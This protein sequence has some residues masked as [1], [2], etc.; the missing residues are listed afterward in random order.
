MSEEK[1]KTVTMS[2]SDLQALLARL[3]KL[4]QKDEKSESEKNKA[5]HEKYLAWVREENRRLEE[6]V[7][8]TAHYDGDK[9]KGYAQI[10]VNGAKATVLRGSSVM[11]KRKHKLVYDQAYEQ[12]V[13]ANEY[14]RS[15]AEKS[16]IALREIQG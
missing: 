1:K 14:A 13:K 9:Y 4:E 8:F 5:E 7:P 10:T 11:I 6:R 3:D 15:Q 12:A 2:E 16:R